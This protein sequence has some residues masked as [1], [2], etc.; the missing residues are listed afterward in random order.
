MLEEFVTQN[1][2]IIE[3]NVVTNVVV[4]DGDTTQ[5][6]PPAGSIALVQSITP[7]MIWQLNAE[8]T[9][10]VLTEVIGAGTINDT[11]DGTK[12]ITDEPKPN[13]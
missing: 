5:W 10:F 13:I 6:T 12:C 4:W 7:A 8:Q 1:Y 11:W 2:L 3:N 9:D